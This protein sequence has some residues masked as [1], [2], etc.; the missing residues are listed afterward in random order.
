MKVGV[1]S[2]N[3]A[4]CKCHIMHCPG[5]R[6]RLYMDTNLSYLI[7][8]SS[9]VASGKEDN[10]DCHIL[11]GLSL[12]LGCKQKQRHVCCITNNLYLWLQVEMETPLS[13][14][15][16]SLSLVATGNEDNLGCHPLLGLC[17]WLQP[18][19]K[20]TWAVTPY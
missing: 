15:T 10:S 6:L 8:S 2:R 9:L 17:L 18:E 3:E 7:Q 11:P 1:V 14:L 19:M 16:P 4:T 12:W 5:L 20:T 13:H